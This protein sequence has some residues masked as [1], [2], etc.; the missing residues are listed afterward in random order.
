MLRRQRKIIVGCQH[1]Q[2]MPDAKLREQRVNRA[3]LH[4]GGPTQV[5]QPRGIDVIPPIWNDQR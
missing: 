2:I 3:Q 5:A 1:C 4:T